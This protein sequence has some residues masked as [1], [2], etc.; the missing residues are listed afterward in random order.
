MTTTVA[1]ALAK[2]GFA[3]AVAAA[4]VNP[5]VAQDAIP[6][7]FGHSA[8]RSIESWERFTDQFNAGI[9]LPRLPGAPEC[10]WLEAGTMMTGPLG[11]HEYA[12]L[13][14]AQVTLPDGD[15]VWVEE[16]HV[17]PRDLDED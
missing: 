12:G 17:L 3:L 8:C 9:S 11:R 4:S 2:L 13:A 1:T 15:L 10:R 16:A 14:F 7:A 5:A 6:V